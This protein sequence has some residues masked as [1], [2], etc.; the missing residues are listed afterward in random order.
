MMRTLRWR[1]VK[2]FVWA[3]NTQQ[4]PFWGQQPQFSFWP[5]VPLHGH[6]RIPPKYILNLFFFFFF[7]KRQHAVRINKLVVTTLK[8]WWHLWLLHFPEINEAIKLRG[9]YQANLF[10]RILTLFSHGGAYWCSCRLRFFFPVFISNKMLL[11]DVMWMT[12]CTSD[13]LFSSPYLHIFTSAPGSF[14]LFKRPVS[15]LIK[16]KLK[17]HTTKCWLPELSKLI[18]RSLLDCSF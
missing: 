9:Q 1:P 8:F 11:L 6:L 10:L 15:F 5:P 7:P 2:G 3:Q 13:D 4:D 18:A 12:F 16:A 17:I 14:D